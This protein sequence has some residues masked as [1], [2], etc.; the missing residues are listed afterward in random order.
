MARASC[1]SDRRQSTLVP[2]VARA[3]R[4]FRVPMKIRACVFLVLAPLFVSAAPLGSVQALQKAA[5][6]YHA[7]I[8]VPVFPT[9]PQQIEQDKKAAIDAGNAALE[10]IAKQDPK[11]APYESTF[12]ALDQMA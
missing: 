12:G 6:P 5:Q 9:T 1:R 8:R 3:S 2:C 7:E 11:Q 4:L 10:R